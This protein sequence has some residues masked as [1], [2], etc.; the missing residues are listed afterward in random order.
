MLLFGNLLQ[1][2]H[3]RVADLGLLRNGLGGHLSAM[4]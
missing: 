2:R 1:T 3:L 4:H